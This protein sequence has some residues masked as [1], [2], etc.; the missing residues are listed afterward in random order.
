MFFWIQSSLFLSVVE[1]L[2]DKEKRDKLWEI[3]FERT[4][5]KFLPE[6]NLRI[7]NIERRLANINRNLI[8]PIHQSTTRDIPLRLR[9]RSSFDQQILERWKMLVEQCKTSEQLPWKLQKLIIRRRFRRY[10]RGQY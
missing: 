1:E 10:Y 2:V 3:Y 7:R 5:E 8:L 4:N 6:E 9:R